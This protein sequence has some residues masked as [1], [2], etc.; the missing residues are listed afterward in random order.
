MKQGDVNE[1]ISPKPADFSKPS[2]VSYGEANDVILM[3]H[4]EVLFLRAE[5]AMRYGTS[6][7][8]KQMY[9]AAVTAHFEFVG[10]TEAE[11]ASYLQTNAPYN[12]AASEVAKSDLIGVQKWI[13]MNGLQESEGWIESRRFDRPPTNIFTN[14]TTGIFD[15]PSRSTLPTAIYPSIRLYPQSEI[16]L[17]AQNVPARTITDKVFWDN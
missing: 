2:E 15:T 12:E 7:D 16:S 6:D 4:W 9:D 11:A 14:P 10:L 8:E 1:L 5:A 13:S 17:N 3:S